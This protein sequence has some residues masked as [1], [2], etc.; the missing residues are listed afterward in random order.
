M[1]AGDISSKARIA[2]EENQFARLAK[3]RELDR[4]GSLK[5]AIYMY[6]QLVKEGC[7]NAQLYLRL[8]VIYR[9]LKQYDDEIRVMEKALQVWRDF[10]W[11][12]LVNKGEPMMAQ[13][14]KRLEKAKVLKTRSQRIG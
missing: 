5:E 4:S 2:W 6:E 13:F 8:A 1:H 10:D 12:D 9:G 11:G 14:T 3:A 7:G